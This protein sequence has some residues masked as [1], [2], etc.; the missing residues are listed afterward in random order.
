MYTATTSADFKNIHCQNCA[1]KLIR[2]TKLDVC[3]GVCPRWYYLIQV[4]HT[5]EGTFFSFSWI[6]QNPFKQEGASFVFSWTSDASWAET[7]TQYPSPS[8]TQTEKIWKIP[9]V[10][11]KSKKLFE[12]RLKRCSVMISVYIKS[13]LRI[14]SWYD[15]LLMIIWYEVKSIFGV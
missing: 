9:L 2:E 8:S 14:K 13:W 6:T 11:W 5:D 7:R 1:D 3:I 10:F 15:M 4:H 12:S